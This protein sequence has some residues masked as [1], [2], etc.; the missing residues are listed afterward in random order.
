M[1][2]LLLLIAGSIIAI[3]AQAQTPFVTEN[4]SSGAFSGTGLPTGWSAGTFSGFSTWHWTNTASSSTYSIGAIASPTASNGWMIFDA[5]ASTT[6]GSTPS[7]WMQSAQYDCS[8]HPNVRLSFANYYRSFFDSCF[9]WVSTSPSFAAGTYTS[10]PVL[11]NNNLFTNQFTAN[12]STVNIN[13][14]AVAGSSPSVYI[15]YVYYG[16]AGGGYSWLVDDMSLSDMNPHDVSISKSFL[17]EAN[18]SAYNSSIFSTPLAFVDTVFPV[19]FLS[20]EGSSAEAT[21]PVSAQIFLGATSVFNQTVNFSGLAS[22]GID[23]LV[24]FN[25]YKPTAVGSYSCVFNASVTGDANLADNN[26]TTLFNVTDTTWMVNAGFINN[27]YISY[28]PSTFTARMNGARF[29]V[30]STS[31]GDTVTGFGVSFGAASSP[32]SFGAGVSVQLYSTDQFSSNWTYVGTS[33]AK[34]ISSSD[35]SSSSIVWAYFPADNLGSGGVGSFIL[36][37]GKSYAAVVQLDGVSTLLT[38]N[39]TDA[40]NAT[41]YSGYFGQSDASFNDGSIS[42]GSTIATGMPAAV[43]MVRMYFGHPCLPP[44]AGIISGPASVCAGSQISLTA[45]AT[46]GAWSSVYPSIAMV[47]S[48]GVVMG[49]N[50]GVDTIKYSVTNGCGTGVARAVV[51]VNPLPNAGTISGPTAVCVGQQITLSTTGTVGGMWSLSNNSLAFLSTTGV[52]TGG[53]AGVDTVVYIVTNSCG[54]AAAPYVVTIGVPNPGIISGP[55][56]VCIGFSHAIVLTTSVSGGTWTVSNSNASVSGS[57]GLIG[58][59]AGTD[60]VKYTTISACGATTTTKLIVISDCTAGVNDI[61]SATAG[62]SVYPN[63]AADGINVKSATTIT[64]IQVMN[65]LGQDVYNK[66]NNTNEAFIDLSSQPAGVYIVR[67]NDSYN[68]RIIKN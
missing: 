1:K 13:I 18:S 8:A 27:Q 68:V 15:R 3:S 53:A 54:T 55:D 32:T 65:L 66:T 41:G 63:P 45:S 12:P 46:G 21:V 30:P 23:S 64:K 43:P 33:V 61:H 9:I 2:K 29:D 50:A 38:I 56:T 37:P 14:S 17:F 24:E 51:T 25:G 5:D 58:L 35:I 26:D 57:G 59:V 6:G 22:P 19:T 36:Q 7:G 40:P 52:L 62:I 39:A 10:Y 49:M 20:N 16:N 48:A 44:S 31:T 28:N 34:P 11:L 60:T 4:F 67:V 42:F 47:N